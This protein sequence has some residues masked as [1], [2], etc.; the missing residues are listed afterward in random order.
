MRNRLILLFIAE[1]NTAGLLPIRRVTPLMTG[2]FE[3]PMFHVLAIPEPS[4]LAVA[5]LLRLLVYRDKLLV[6]LPTHALAVSLTEMVLAE[7]TN[8]PVPL[9]ALIKLLNAS[10]TKLARLWETKV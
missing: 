9:L 4:V 1:A 6:Q 8:A 2:P 7:Y 5:R 3:G 10:S